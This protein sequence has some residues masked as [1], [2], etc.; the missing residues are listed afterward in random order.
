MLDGW[1]GSMDKIVAASVEFGLD[2]IGVCGM[3]Q[4]G[5]RKKEF[6]GIEGVGRNWTWIYGRLCPLF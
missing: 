5:L 4:D 2:R 6:D 1:L 3:V